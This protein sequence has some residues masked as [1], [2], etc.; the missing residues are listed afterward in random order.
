MAFQSSVLRDGEWVTETVNFQDALKAST[1]PKTN[2]KPR[3]EPPVCGV[4][5]RTLIESPVVHWVLPVWIRSRSHNDVAFVGDHFVQISELRDDGQAHEVIRKADFGSRI[6]N[7]LVL[8]TPPEGGPDGTASSVIKTEDADILMQDAPKPHEGNARQPLPP[9]LLVLILESSDMVFL[10]VRELPDH[11]LEFVTTKYESPRNLKYL[12]YHFIIN[13]SSRYIAAGSA[14]GAFIIYELETLAN[15]STQYQLQGYYQPVKNLKVRIADGI[16]HKLEFLY[17]RPEDDYHIIL[18]IIIVRR[19]AIRGSHISRMVVYDWEAS[20]DVEGILKLEKAGTPLPK[21]HRMPLMIIPLRINTAFIAVSEHAIGIVKN[22]FTGQTSFDTLETHSP[23]QTNLHHGAAGPLWTA[24][25]RPFRLNKYF[26]KTDII[27]LARE[28]G[29]IAHIELDSADLLPSVTTVG[30]ISTNIST[31]FTTAYDVFSDVFIIGGE[32]GPGGIWKLAARSDP[33]QVSTIANWSPVVDMATTD[34]NDSWTDGVA[35][36]DRSG[37]SKLSP[38][39]SQKPDRIFC[40]SGRGPRS[41]LTELRWGIQ[42]RIGLE[43]DYD[44]VVRQSWM[45]PVESQGE[46]GFYAILS[47][48]H[49]SD[50]LHFPANLSNASALSSEVSPFDTNSRTISVCQNDQGTIVQVTETSTS[51]AASSQSSRH[52]HGD[53]CGLDSLVADNACCENDIVVISSHNGQAS[54]LDVL[55]IDQ[56]NVTKVASVDTAGEVT[57]LSLFTLLGDTYIVV[58]SVIDGTPWIFNYTLDGQEVRSHSIV[59][60]CEYDAQQ[61][62][63]RME[64]FTSI[65]AVNDGPNKT[66]LVFG[67]RSGH[68]VTVR[69]SNDGIEDISMTVEQLGLA[70]TKVSPASG[71]FAGGPAFFVCC[72]NSLWVMTDFSEQETKFKTKNLIWPTDSSDPSLPAPPIHAVHCLADSLSNYP[73]HMSLMLLAGT[74]ILLVDIWPHVGP[75]PR[76]IP[77]AGTPVRVIYSQTWK[78][79]VVAHFDEED[80]STLSFIDPDSGATISSASDKSK[81]PSQHISGLGHVGD[82]I[83]GLN[84]WLY[85]KDGKTFP[86]LIV[87]TQQG[88][89][90][91]VSVKEKKVETENGPSRELQYWTRYKK[92]GFSAPVYS[93]VGDAVGL[94]FCVGDTLQWEV[95]DLAEKRLKP[96]KEFRLDSPAISLRV[97]GSKVFALTA[98]HSMLVIDL[99]VE[100]EHAEASLIHCDQVVRYMSHMV[101]MGDSEDQLGEWPL[102]L[103]STSQADFSGVW[104]PRGQRNREFEVV[105]SGK[106]PTSIRKF[107]RGHTRPF[108]VAANRQ[109]QYNTLFSTVDQAEVLG[110][111]LDGSLQHFALIGLDLWRFLRLVQNLAKH[112]K[113]ICP[114]EP[115]NDSKKKRDEDEDMYLDLEPQMVPDKMHVDG[116]VLKRCFDRRALETLVS[117]GDGLDL[118][119][120]YLDGI[121]EGK[122]TKAFR[123]DGEDGHEKYLELGY[124]ILEHVLAPVI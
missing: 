97:E 17:P 99:H 16:I 34:G 21:E 71:P 92:K 53:V 10:F 33:Q 116:D 111:S 48:P 52:T 12:G 81:K 44:Q 85:V 105:V 96:M 6:R 39:L 28:D 15:M 110:V 106:L 45:F 89:L 42:A 38:I 113:D 59:S 94:L 95:L 1:A 66:I 40:T 77:L 112:D 98:M 32:S 64:A 26:E 14:E 54:R 69:I 115:G 31:A 108:W 88:R 60:H 7:A 47:M 62:Q 24:W 75:V 23:S 102:N 20:D 51:L 50:V 74:R 124:E 37:R 117:M 109:R 27:Y 57:C 107:Q 79:L 123:I 76:S 4:L 72:D 83:F 63:L 36:Q 56:M 29:V 49:S 100:S 78:C 90:M 84:E 73:Q 80:R 68:L 61:L 93:A 65:S 122:H 3:A 11:T 19:E 25:A 35:R 22:A 82:K 118:F 91:I 8:G 121:D 67:T 70:P 9:Q 46:R 41:S 30:T 2:P 55:R 114:F 103:L 86:F 119:C 101:E 5:T 58:G 87:T 43:F 120:E 104:V 13:P 18:L